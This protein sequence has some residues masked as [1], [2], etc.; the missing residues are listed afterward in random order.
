MTRRFQQ[1]QPEERVMLQTLKEQGRSVRFI[2]RSL[3]RSAAS[4]SRELRR[5]QHDGGY[6]WKTAQA[7]CVAR[8]RATRPAAKLDPDGPLWP[9]VAHMLGWY[10]S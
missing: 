9:L 2:G 8:R 5:N 7:A 1:L 6:A 4:L 10:W 3:G